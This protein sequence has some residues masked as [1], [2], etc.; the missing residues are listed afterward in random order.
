MWRA[1]AA[2]VSAVAAA[3]AGLVTALVTTHPSWGLWVALAVAVVVGAS[4]QAV[5]AAG[6][7][8]RVS[9]SGVG[10]VAVGGSAHEIHT[11]VAAGRATPFGGPDT[12]DGVAASAPGSVAVGGDATGP[13]STDVTDAEEQ[14]RP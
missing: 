12:G 6:D 14:A 1:V 3:G 11:R 10:S 2:G 13:I 7:R 9:A 5:A 8:R 4:T